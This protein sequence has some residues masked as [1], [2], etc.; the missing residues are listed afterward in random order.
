MAPEWP[1]AT[2]AK[3]TTNK[4]HMGAP[5]SNANVPHPL[6]SMGQKR[7]FEGANTSNLEA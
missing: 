5:E 1:G 6:F 4:R 7:K 3:F 2:S